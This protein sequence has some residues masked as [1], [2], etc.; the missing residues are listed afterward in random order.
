MTTI[1]GSVVNAILVNGLHAIESIFPGPARLGT[2]LP[3]PAGSKHDPVILVS[4]F[5]NRPHGWVEWVRSLR[6]DGF[7]VHVFEMP[8]SGLGD[9]HGSAAALQTFAEQVRSRSATGM[10]DLVGFSEGGIVSRL[11]TALYG[12]DRFVDSIVTLATPHNGVELSKL[13]KVA[14]MLPILGSAIPEA[15]RQLV[16]GAELLQS[17][18][19]L[20]AQLRAAKKIR[21]TSIYARDIDGFVSP[22]A[23]HLSGA[24][25]IPLDSERHFLVLRG[26]SHYGIYHSSHAAYEAA[27]GALL[28]Q[29][30]VGRDAKSAQAARKQASSAAQ[31]HHRQSAQQQVHHAQFA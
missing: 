3:A 7:D 10:V 21:Y 19:T 2:P 27:R 14:S 1:A 15:A 23:A 5:A 24:T 26:P 11:F 28:V 31:R 25:N 30:L 20:D 16:A 17:L 22:A 18:N 13:L 4:G 6:T 9:V 29:N 12:G 8:T